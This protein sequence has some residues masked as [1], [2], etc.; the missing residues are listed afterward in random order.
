MKP[1]QDM[2]KSATVR[3]GQMPKDLMILRN[4]NILYTENGKSIP[5]LLDSLGREVPKVQATDAP[6]DILANVDKTVNSENEN[7]P[8]RRDLVDPYFLDKQEQD[9]VADILDY[10]KQLAPDWLSEG[11]I[12][13]PHPS[14]SLRSQSTLSDLGEGQCSAYP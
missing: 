12:K 8:S 13:S 10:V 6:T 4:G 3:A 5:E 9:E 14:C 11:E 1:R 2:L 7:F